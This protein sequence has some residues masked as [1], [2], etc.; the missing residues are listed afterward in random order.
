MRSLSKGL[1]LVLFLS[2]VSLADELSLR[3]QVL[4]LYAD[5]RQAFDISE[6]EASALVGNAQ[7]P[8]LVDVRE[9]SERAVSM[10]PGAIDKA[11]FESLP[12]AQR[13]G[14]VIYC[15]IGR[16][17]GLYV[18]SL[19]KQGIHTS[20]LSGGILDWLH[21][22]GQLAKDG[23]VTQ[24]VHVYGRRWNLAPNAFETQWYWWAAF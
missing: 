13:Q 6:V 10:I 15:T 12:L 24:K 20:N 14:A 3:E 22:G 17:S 21:A 18:E 2:T 11:T 7:M 8:L 5:T 23:Q 4:Q 9:K 19:A 1:W 16:R